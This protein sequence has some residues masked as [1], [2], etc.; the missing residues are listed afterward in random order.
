MTRVAAA[1]M[2][3]VVGWEPERRCWIHGPMPVAVR[4]GAYG[5]SCCWHCALIPSRRA[6][7]RTRS[8]EIEHEKSPTQRCEGSRCFG[9]NHDDD[10]LRAVRTAIEMQKAVEELNAEWAKEDGPQIT[11]G[12]GISTGEVIVGN[13]G[14][15]QRLEFTGV[16]P[17]V[18]YAQRIES[19][20][21]IIPSQILIN[22][23]TYLRVK[24][25]VCATRFGPLEIKGKK[26]P[27][28][29]YGIDGIQD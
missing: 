23:S 8:V 4:F 9:D 15:E 3:R 11:I 21:K 29:V 19:L 1:D 20:T 10:P 17:D 12:I 22:E 18:N 27:I 26:E 7:T 5:S 14:S 24:D 6:P 16:G 2:Y 13:I 28:A 25:D